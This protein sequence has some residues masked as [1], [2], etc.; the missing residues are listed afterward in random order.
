MKEEYTAEELKAYF[1]NNCETLDDLILRLVE[2][3]VISANTAKKL[4][5]H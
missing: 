4:Y 5:L 2:K 3:Q 1:E